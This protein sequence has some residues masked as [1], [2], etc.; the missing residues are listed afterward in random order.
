MD[1]TNHWIPAFAGMTK[2]SDSGFCRAA[3]GLLDGLFPTPLYCL[4]GL[5]PTWLCPL[6]RLFP[7]RS[8]TY[9]HAGV[10]SRRI[11]DFLSINDDIPP[12]G[13]QRK[14][15]SRRGRPRDE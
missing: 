8:T 3:S 9:I 5:F 14:L 6:D 11:P 10:P 7:T 13:F 12:P 2:W 4:G 15:E 1:D